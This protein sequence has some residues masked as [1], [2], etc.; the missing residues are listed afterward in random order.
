LRIKIGNE[1]IPLNILV[2]L[3]IPVIIFSPSSV[4]QIIL[5]LP[6]I[7]FFPGYVLMA[8]LFPRRGGMG[9]AERM[10]L[11]LGMSII[12]V[13]LIGLILNYSWWGI[14]LE[15][16][17]YSIAPFILTMS[18]IAWFRRK[19]LPR[20]E[21]F[22]IEFQLGIPSLGI[23]TLD[24][25]LSIILVVAI[26][27]ALGTLGYVIAAPKIGETFT[28]FYLLGL[29]GK[30]MDFP[31]ELRVGEEGK[32]IVGIINQERETVTY[33]VEVKIDG[34]EN[35]Q[36]EGITL[37]HDEKWEEEVSFVPPQKGE[38]Q[39]VEFLLFKEGEAEPYLEPLRLW[40]DVKG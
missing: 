15:A 8:A 26:V 12:V 21:R 1:L 10:A 38:R 4:L 39:R 34:V 6:F 36:V 25:V 22:G 23:G 24:K 20:E 37:E 17:L 16:A 31:Q 14:S 29:S 9:N 18:I 30:A 2:L 11:S 19:R 32:V 3:L 7:L 13:S 5:G 40:L 28:E 33:R 35:N 27:A